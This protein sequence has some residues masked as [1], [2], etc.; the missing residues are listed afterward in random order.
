MIGL[1]KPGDVVS[2]TDEVGSVWHPPLTI[3]PHPSPSPFT[4]TLHRH[5]SPS[6]FILH[7]SPFTLHPTLNPHS[8]TF[9]P[10]PSP[11]CTLRSRMMMVPGSKSPETRFRST[12]C[13]R[14]GLMTR[15]MHSSATLERK[16]T[17]SWMRCVQVHGVCVRMS[18][19]LSVCVCVYGE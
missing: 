18:V 1:L 16:G 17:N 11:H 8:P 12:E 15:A 7:P 14:E 5:P 13:P 4:V 6:P 9:T 3:H 19:C 10:D 2:Y